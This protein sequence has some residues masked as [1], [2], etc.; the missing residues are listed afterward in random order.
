[1]ANVAI[2]VSATLESITGSKHVYPATFADTGHNL[3]G[4][5]RSTGKALAVLI[6]SV[7]SFANRIEAELAATGVLPEIT[8]TVGDRVLSIHELPHRAYDAILR[9]SLLNEVPWRHSEIGQAVLANDLTN[10]TSLYTYAPMTLLLGGWD[11]HGGDA[12]TGAK[13]ARSVACEIWGYGVQTSKHCTQRLD[14]LDIGSESEKHAVIDGILQPDKSGKKPSELGHGDVPSSDQKGVFVDSIEFSG[15]IS[16]TRLSRYNFPDKDGKTT[17]ERDQAAR[18]VLVQLAIV[19]ISR[20]MD[21]LDLRSGCELYTTT[22]QAHMISV[23]G[24]KTNVELSSSLEKLE[25]AI[26]LASKQGLSFVSDPVELMAGEALQ[27]LA[28][29]GGV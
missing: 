3:V 6:D 1:M 27:R 11:S 21:N 29:K 4:F 24:T 12:G 26:D 25:E 18:E 14:P 17:I 9:D 23:D 15:A 13:I 10:A 20:V 22:R 2:S 7:G 28:A 5:D 8:T 16:L 19:G